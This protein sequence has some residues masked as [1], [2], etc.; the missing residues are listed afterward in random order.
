MPFKRVFRRLTDEERKRDAE[1]IAAVKK[2]FP[3][4]YPTRRR[5]AP[6]LPSAI[7]AAREAQGLT[8]YALAQKA[9]VPNQGTIRVIELGIDVMVGTLLAVAHALGLELELVPMS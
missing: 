1:I 7:R 3:P 6:G 9:G 8:W 4:K 2:E 5:A